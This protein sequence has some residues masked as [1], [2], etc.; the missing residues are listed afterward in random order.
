M[1]KHADRRNLRRRNALLS[2][3]FVV[4][5]GAGSA[6]T[7][8]ANAADE[9]YDQAQLLAS[10][11]EDTSLYGRADS[12]RFEATSYDGFTGNLQQVSGVD[13]NCGIADITREV[14]WTQST[15]ETNSIEVSASVEAGLSKIFSASVSTTFGHTWEQTQGKEDA[16]LVDR[17]ILDSAKL[18]EF[19]EG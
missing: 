6:A 18:K 11:P 14:R 10:C 5:V 4:A 17:E 2:G 1:V 7:L 3:I 19:L 8:A 9:V 12:C 13:T 16:R 15:S